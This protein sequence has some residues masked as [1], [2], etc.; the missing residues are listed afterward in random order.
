MFPYL[1]SP[2]I[3]SIK[4]HDPY[5]KDN[6]I[7]ID[8]E[9][10]YTGDCEISFTVVTAL[11]NLDGVLKVNEIAGI[12]RIIVNP[13]TGEM[14]LAFVNYPD[15]NYTL[16]GLI[17]IGLDTIRENI[18]RAIEDTIVLPNTVTFNLSPPTTPVPV[19]QEAFETTMN[20]NTSIPNRQKTNNDA[21]DN[22]SHDGKMPIDW[23]AENGFQWQVLGVVAGYIWSKTDVSMIVYVAL[24]ILV[25]AHHIYK[26]KSRV[27]TTRSRRRIRS[28]ETQAIHD[29]L[30]LS[31]PP[32]WVSFPDW[33]R[34]EWINKIV[35]HMWLRG[36]DYTSTYVKELIEYYVREGVYADFTLDHYDFGYVPLRVEGAKVYKP[37]VNAKMSKDEIIIDLDASYFGDNELS[38]KIQGASSMVRNIQIQGLLRLV[39]K[40]VSV[41]PLII[42]LEIY[43][44][45]KPKIDFVLDGAVSPL[46][47]PGL[48]SIVRSIVQN[49]IAELMVLP[50]KLSLE[51]INYEPKHM[52]DFSWYVQLRR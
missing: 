44:I 3:E 8:L 30:R 47:L 29:R 36:C 39:L 5:P 45:N 17:G 4:V 43:F 2:R 46:N 16:D 11:P 48:K 10:L 15:I 27:E 33:E 42:S 31:D 23:P 20:H 19:A 37:T 1:Q 52:Q 35:K 49:Q 24:V 34:C 13:H 18:E 21:T 14:K 50:Q 51:L 12:L 22:H 25:V 7:I 41:Q 9:I 38:F 6:I 28:H 40:H 26:M 32:T